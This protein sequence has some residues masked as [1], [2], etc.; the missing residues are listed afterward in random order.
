MKF[1]ARL[2]LS[3]ASLLTVL[4]LLCSQNALARPLFQMPVPEGETWTVATYSSHNPQLA[5]DMNWG[6]TA[7]AD[8]GKTIVASADGTVIVSE[9]STTTGYG[10]YIV[11]DHGG[12]WTTLHAHLNERTVAVGQKVKSGQK[13]GTCGRSSAKYTLATH[14]HYEQKLNGALQYIYFNGSQIPYYAKTNITSRN[15]YVAAA[16]AEPAQ[17]PGVFK[18]VAKHSGK[19][20]DVQNGNTADGAN[21]WQ[22]YVNDSNAQR[23]Q[24]SHVADGYYSIKNL[25]SNKFMSV[26]DAGTANGTNVRQW[27]WTGTCAQLWRFE[28]VGAGFH[29]VIN[30]CSGKL[31]DVQGGPAATGDGTNIQIWDYAPGNDNQLWRIETVPAKYQVLAKHS[32]K[33]ADVQYGNGA[34]GTNIWQWYVNDSNAQR[35]DIRHVEDGYFSFKNLQTGK[36][37]GVENAGTANGTNVRQ[38]DWT[39]T[40]AQLWKLVSV[41]DGHLKV[42]NKCS[43]RV[44]DV[45]GGQG[46]TGDGVNI[47]IYDYVNWTNQMWR[48]VPVN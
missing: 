30:K 32:G 20:A 6:S 11:I 1:I 13:I 43:G 37:M 16:P 34:N 14:L 31:L 28:S 40:C 22:W 45:A 23:W 5:A 29:K 44:L 9:Y 12:G 39:G 47:Q 15:K 10:H 19:V 7:E 38:W 48:L 2:N 33:A 17:Y 4:L 27:S 8:F 36:I 3:L 26:Q 41:G 21:I 25:I 24:I 35:W 46:A 18:L 42:A